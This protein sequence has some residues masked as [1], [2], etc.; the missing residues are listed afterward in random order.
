MI[1][2]KT[3]EWDSND[4]MIDFVVSLNFHRRKS[5]H[6][7]EDDAKDACWLEKIDTAFRGTEGAEKGESRDKATKLVNS[8]GTAVNRAA[9][10]IKN[11]ISDLV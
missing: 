3:K 2:P 5:K 8:S 4:N 10:V 9:K 1:E 7:F 6:I 11:G